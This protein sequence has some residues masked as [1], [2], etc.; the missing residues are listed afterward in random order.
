VSDIVQKRLAMNIDDTTDGSGLNKHGRALVAD[1][2]A[3]VLAGFADR[4]EV[5]INPVGGLQ[6]RSVILF[7]IS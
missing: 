2:I 4:I 1:T 5:V 3:E 6:H 7:T